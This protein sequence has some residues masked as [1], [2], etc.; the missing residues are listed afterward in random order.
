MSNSRSSVQSLTKYPIAATVPAMMKAI[1]TESRGFELRRMS[2]SS[3][4]PPRTDGL[5]ATS[6]SSPSLVRPDGEVVR[7]RR[8]RSISRRSHR[9]YPPPIPANRS[10][11]LS[12]GRT[13][14]VTAPP[15]IHPDTSSSDAAARPPRVPIR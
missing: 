11:A 3:S 7:V 14:P 4:T 8:S 15:S 9:T 13:R 2:R 5:Y 12:V 10:S 6:P 1:K